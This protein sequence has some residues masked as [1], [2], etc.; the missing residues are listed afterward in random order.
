M[1]VALCDPRLSRA[2]NWLARH[3]RQDAGSGS[4]AWRTG[5]TFMNERELHEKDREILK[6]AGTRRRSGKRGSGVGKPGPT[7]NRTDHHERA[8]RL[9]IVQR[10]QGGMSQRGL[11]TIGN[12]ALRVQL[13]WRG[14][15][16]ARQPKATPAVGRVRRAS[17]SVRADLA[18]AARQVS[19]HHHGARPCR[20]C[21]RTVVIDAC[22][23]CGHALTPA[24]AARPNQASRRKWAHGVYDIDF[25]REGRRRVP[26]QLLARLFALRQYLHFV[27]SMDLPTTVREHVHAF[28]HHRRRRPRLPVRQ[29]QAV[30]L[31]HDADGASI[32]PKFLAFATH[33]DFR[34]QACR[35][36]ARK[37]KAKSNATSLMSN[38]TCSTVAPSRRWSISTR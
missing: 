10:R 5:C 22:V 32:I 3:L 1:P 36:R 25:T 24:C 35:V 37:R 2:G 21:K 18:G 13:N 27:E 14:C 28:H 15:R 9:E 29:L 17:S 20:D 12:L 23:C 31:C 7:S 33:P 26:L 6:P 19:E 8:M 38:P 4:C 34:P 11:P 30:V 16:R